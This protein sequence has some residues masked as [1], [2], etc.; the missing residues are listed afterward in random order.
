VS[1]ALVLQTFNMLASDGECF[2]PCWS[3]LCSTWWPGRAE[4]NNGT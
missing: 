2:W 1:K 3:P 4:N